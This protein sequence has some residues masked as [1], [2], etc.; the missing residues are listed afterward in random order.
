MPLIW[1]VM[2][3]DGDK[4]QVGRGGT[5]LGVRVGT[6][7]PGQRSDIDQDEE[8]LV[9]P[10]RGGMSISPN[11]DALP[12]HCLPRRLRE[13]Y[14]DRFPQAKG[15]DT[16]HC[17]CLGEGPFEA[18]PV[19]ERLSLRLDPDRPDRHGFVEP[20]ATMTLQDYET[21]LAVTQGHWRRWEE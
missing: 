17:W 8:G 19:A 3:I 2:K 9:H 6:V 21:A 7:G 18:A 5:L 15:Q 20:A 13:K 16:L 4:P 12:P 14:P 1:R 10:G 11:V